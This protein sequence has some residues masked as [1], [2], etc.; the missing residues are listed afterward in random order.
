MFDNAIDN[1]SVNVKITMRNMISNANHI[2]P[3][4]FWTFGKHLSFR[5]V[6]NLMDA[7]SN[8]FNQHT[9]GSKLL[10]TIRRKIIIIRLFYISIPFL[11]L[12]DCSL[13]LF[14]NTKNALL[15]I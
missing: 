14:K 11:Q 9:T 13:N 5:N 2:F 15:F 10:H 8:G 12:T 7:F 3:R 4:Y 6:I 1:L